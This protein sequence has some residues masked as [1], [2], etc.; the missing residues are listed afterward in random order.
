MKKLFDDASEALNGRSE[1]EARQ[2]LYDQMRHNGLRRRNKPFPGAADLHFP[3]IDMNIRK[4]KP[5]WESQATS[6]ERLASFVS[7]QDQ[8]AE[9]TSAAADFFDFELKQNT[10]FEIEL[11]HLVDRMLCRGRGVLKAIVDPFD[12]NKIVFETIDPMFI[13]V[14][15]GADDFVD[16]DWFVHVKHMSVAKY[17]RD[18]RYEQDD[19]L[20]NSIRGSKDY[21][22]T[23]GILEDKQ[24]REGINFSRNKDQIILW[25]HW[26][27]TMGGWT[28]HTYS[29]QAPD[30][31]VR[32]PFGCP[33]KLAGKPSCPF[34]SFKT[35]VKE[36][37]WYAPRGLPELNAAFEA[38]TCKLWNEKT[39]AMTFANRPVFTSQQPIANTGNLR[40]APGEYIPGGVQQVQTNGPS[41]SF[42]QEIAFTRS[43]SEQ[44]SM[45]PDFG[46]VQSGGNGDTGGKPRTATENNRIANLQSVGTESNGKIFRMDLAKLYRHVWG[47]MLQF[48]RQKLSFYVSGEIKTLPEQALH[49]AYLI[50]PDG[51]PDQWNKQLRNQRAMQRLQAFSG[52]PNVDQDELV[53]DAMATD[54][55][56]FAQ[57]AFIPTN[58]KAASEGEDEAYEIVILQDGFPAAVK[59]NEDHATRIHTLMSWLMKQSMSG[60][61]PNPIA[62]QRVQQHLAVHFQFLKKLQPEAAKQVQMQIM[63]MESQGAG[64]RPPGPK[65]PMPAQAE[66]E[67]A[68]QP[69]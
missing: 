42:D 65:P 10:N 6:T 14:A 12:D 5:F 64:A 13:I 47:L 43:T 58:L 35:E 23:G 55:P 7:L 66:E 51:T 26:V 17:K 60:V 53:R 37:G 45:L 8:Q 28:V 32:R 29:P 63:Q 27:K 25:E 15:E 69:S 40:W 11:L 21:D 16:A 4:G 19:G 68:G 48:K 38:Y 44:V 57:R 31:T 30:K 2:R 62:I 24:A 61:P 1:W 41:Y 34:Y 52:A 54:D 46:I 3:L 50:A 18:R 67:F 49:D 33:Y 39:D 36:K 22:A 56:K 59:P 9:T 20:I